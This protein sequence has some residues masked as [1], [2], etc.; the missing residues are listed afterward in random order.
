MTVTTSNAPALLDLVT[1]FFEADDWPATWTDDTVH[2]LYRGEHA[3]W[4]CV[5]RV[6]EPERQ[7]VF[8]SIAP[9]TV[10]PE[11]ITEVAEFVNRANDGTVIGNFEIGWDTGEVRYRT[12]VDV[13]GGELTREMWRTLIGINLRAM[14]RY[15]AALTSV[16]N[17]AKSPAVAVA[18]AEADLPGADGQS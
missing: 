4:R 10:D 15:V 17:G 1:G 14:D 11:R 9:L 7:F 16:A 3:L 12:S 2:T 8:Y 5:G 13:E 18:E 6:R